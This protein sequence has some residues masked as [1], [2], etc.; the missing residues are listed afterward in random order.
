[1]GWEWDVYVPG[2]YNKSTKM[3]GVCIRVWT[4]LDIATP[5]RCFGLQLLLGKRVVEPRVHL[6]FTATLLSR[7]LFLCAVAV[8]RFVWIPKEWYHTRQG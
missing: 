5:R 7:A 6:I 1:M 2:W 4:G 8:S 3:R